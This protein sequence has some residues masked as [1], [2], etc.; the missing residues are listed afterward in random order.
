[1][2]NAQLAIDH[3][4]Q[5]TTQVKQKQIL[6]TKHMLCLCCDVMCDEREQRTTLQRA[7]LTSDRART[8]ERTQYAMRSFE[9]LSRHNETDKNVKR[10][11]KQ[12]ESKRNETKSFRR[13]V[14]VV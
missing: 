1:M 9:A 7:L 4:Q 10:K 5:N 12:N 2:L 6:M 13:R 14:D 11:N 3:T 8:E